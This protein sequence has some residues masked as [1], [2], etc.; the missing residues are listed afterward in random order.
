MQR[1]T[2]RCGVCAMRRLFRDGRAKLTRIRDCVPE[3]IQTR[4]QAHAGFM[5]RRVS[6][7]ARTSH[8]A[9]AAVKPNFPSAA[10]SATNTSGAS[11]KKA[12][13]AS[14]GPGPCDRPT[15]CPFTLLHIVRRPQCLARVFLRAAPVLDDDSVSSGGDTG[16][17]AQ[18]LQHMR[19]AVVAVEYR[20]HRARISA[21]TVK[22]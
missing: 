5:L 12:S 6:F 20:E 13:I 10:A 16:N 4:K 1:K 11:S 14:Y 21:A 15:G 18:L 7:H 17:D 8:P 22:K 19:F 2:R 3:S 9:G